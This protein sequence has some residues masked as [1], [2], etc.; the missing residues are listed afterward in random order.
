MVEYA[1]AH[2]H[3]MQKAFVQMNVQ[4]HHVVSDITGGLTPAQYKQLAARAAYLAA[5]KPGQADALTAQDEAT[6]GNS[7]ATVDG[8]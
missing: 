1:S 3:H 4:L 5:M 8:E 2:V 7:G 6:S